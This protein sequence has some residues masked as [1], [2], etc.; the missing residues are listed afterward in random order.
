MSVAQYCRWN[1]RQGA[2]QLVSDYSPYF[3]SIVRF[4]K[5]RHDRDLRLYN[6]NAR[7]LFSYTKNKIKNKKIWTSQYRKQY[8]TTFPHLFK[9]NLAKQLALSKV[10]W[11]KSHLIYLYVLAISLGFSIPMYTSWDVKHLDQV[12]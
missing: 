11:L 12:K 7:I 10:K 4:L 3:S 1:P 5:E 6:H 2:L 8:Y 9:G